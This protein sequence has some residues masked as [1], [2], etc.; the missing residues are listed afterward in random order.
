[1]F[2]SRSLRTRSPYSKISGTT[3]I[4]V[5]VLGRLLGNIKSRLFPA[6]VGRI[7]TT[8]SILDIIVVIAYSYSTDLYYKLSYPYSF[9][10]P[11]NKASIDYGLR[12]LNTPIAIRFV[13]RHSSN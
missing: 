4:V 2:S 1:M 12:G 3:R 13:N 7:H 9:L 6:P 5:L 10:A 11:P 8:Y